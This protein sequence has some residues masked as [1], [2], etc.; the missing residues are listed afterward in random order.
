MSSP[1][2]HRARQEPGLATPAY[3]VL[4]MIVI[5]ART[6]YEVK[7][8]V[9]QSTRF[10]WTISQAQIYPSLEQLE[11]A[12][13]ITGR[14]DP[15]GRRRRRVFEITAAGRAELT[16]WLG[17]DDPMPFELRDTGMLKLFFAD[18]LD[19]D[20]AQALLHAVRR[21]SEDRAGLLRAL[22]PVARAVEE[23]GY[24]HPLL[25]L[26]LGIAVHQAIA[27]VCAAFERRQAAEP[28]T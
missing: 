16:S 18:A 27:D 8:M 22:E 28:M 13:F 1:P 4:G 23:Q 7:Q 2:V 6:G 21:R 12:G 15:Q 24:R 19:H 10:F 26:E 3:V 11:Q 14:E 20:Q 5:G 17:R 9:E 25:T